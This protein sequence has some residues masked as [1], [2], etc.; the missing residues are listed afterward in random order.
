MEA[1]PEGDNIF[2]FRNIQSS[3]DQTASFG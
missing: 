3:F 1:G 2:T